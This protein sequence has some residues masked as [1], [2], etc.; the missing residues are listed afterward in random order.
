MKKTILLL[1]LL[2]SGCATRAVKPPLPVPP[3]PV[4][5]KPAPCDITAY[6]PLFALPCGM[7]TLTWKDPATGRTCSHSW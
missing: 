6:Q 2:A 5:P 7:C 1:G 4:P 3:L